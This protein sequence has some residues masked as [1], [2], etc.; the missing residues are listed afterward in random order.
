MKFI[1]VIITLAKAIPVID[2]WL[3][4]LFDAYV[5]YKSEK[6]KEQTQIEIDRAIETQDQRRVE[7]E[8]HSGVYS[9]HG[10]IRTSLPGVLRD[11]KP[12]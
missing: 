1:S 11:K 8:N 3:E 5:I 4:R 10:D 9:G 12:D 7:N 2:K 6:S